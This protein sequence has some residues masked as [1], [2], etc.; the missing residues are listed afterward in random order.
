MSLG[1]VTFG[2]R[3]LR[4]PPHTVANGVETRPGIEIDHR[5]GTGFIG[6]F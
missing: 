6:R 3:I 5:A 1:S 2:I 4:P